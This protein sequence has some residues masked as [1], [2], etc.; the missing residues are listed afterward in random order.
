MRAIIATL[1]SGLLVRFGAASADT[2][3]YA[4]ACPPAPKGIA[5]FGTTTQLVVVDV[6]VKDKSGNPL[7]GLK[8][9]DFNITED[10]KKQDI[11]IFTYQELEETVDSGTRARQSRPSPRPSAG[12]ARDPCG[13]R[14]EIRHRQPDRALQTRRSEIQGPPPPRHVLRHDQHAHSGPDP[15]PDRRPEVPQDPD[16]ALRP[17]G[18]H[19]LLQRPQSAAGFHRRSRR[20]VQG[21]QRP[22][23]RRRQRSR[24]GRLHRRR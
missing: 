13:A 7:K 8:P 10:G 5:K 16:D 24:R 18:H 1:L 9:A 19:D 11:K 3:G 17:D 14:R 21:H 4:D 6:T 15:R 20:P 22:D 12:S 2:T 23:H